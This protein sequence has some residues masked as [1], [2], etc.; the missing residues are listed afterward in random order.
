M[1]LGLNLILT[2]IRKLFILTCITRKNP[3][4]GE[5]APDGTL[6]C[7]TVTTPVLWSTSWN[8]TVCMRL[9]YRSPPPP[10]EKEEMFWTSNDVTP[11]LG[12]KT[13]ADP[14]T[15]HATDS[16]ESAQTPAELLV[17]Y[18]ARTLFGLVRVLLI[19]VK[20]RDRNGIG[21]FIWKVN[22]LYFWTWTDLNIY[23][24]V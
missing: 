23:V 2:S 21:W 18:L 12:S 15:P 11:A 9:Q 13:R 4:D 24:H 22:V 8:R 17:V 6:E 5:A 7:D 1:F 3:V 16:P 20:Q 14:L 10:K 19:C